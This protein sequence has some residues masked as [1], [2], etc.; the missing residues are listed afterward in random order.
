ME[1]AGEVVDALGSVDVLGDVAS[2]QLRSDADEV[3]AAVLDANKSIEVSFWSLRYFG[4]LAIMA[5]GVFLP[6]AMIVLRNRK[7]FR[8]HSM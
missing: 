1:T 6:L 2:D 4:G 7:S 8:H 5:L 3:L